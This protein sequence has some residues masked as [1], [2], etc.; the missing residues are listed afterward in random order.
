MEQ[1][2]SIPDWSEG[3]GFGIADLD[4]AERRLAT[5]VQELNQAI[6]DGRDREEMQRLTNQLLLDALSHFEYEER[7]F[8]ECAYP[9]PKGHAALH[10]QMRAEL[11][12]ALARVCDAE[13][14]AMRAEYG[15]L[16]KQLFVEHMRQEVRKYR[17]SLR[18]GPISD[19]QTM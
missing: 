7:V 3:M 15:L 1:T 9:L 18:P 4:A 11:E 2:E 16:V 6:A 17:A 12:H 13:S 14:Q 19:T 8:S 5:L 10:V